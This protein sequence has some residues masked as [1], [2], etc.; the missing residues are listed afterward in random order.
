MAADNQNINRA[1][2]SWSQN[3][4][5]PGGIRY[6]PYRKNDFNPLARIRARGFLMLKYNLHKNG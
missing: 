3:G 6:Y 1:G 4:G 5:V 2:K